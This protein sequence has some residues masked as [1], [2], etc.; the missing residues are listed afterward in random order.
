ME[1]V[2]CVYPFTSVRNPLLL[3]KTIDILDELLYN[4][5][6]FPVKGIKLVP[7][8]F[9]MQPGLNNLTGTTTPGRARCVFVMEI[10]TL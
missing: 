9:K 3:D 6:T 10:D 2:E 1:E 7:L 4:R 5:H 8:N